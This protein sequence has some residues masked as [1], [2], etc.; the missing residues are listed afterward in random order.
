[1]TEQVK[2]KP[3]ALVQ[4]PFGP[5]L[6]AP[7]E[8][9]DAAHA[10]SGK[11]G[12]VYLKRTPKDFGVVKRF[13]PATETGSFGTIGKWRVSRAFGQL[14]VVIVE[15]GGTWQG[16]TV[17]NATL[18]E[19]APR[20]PRELANVPLYNYYAADF[21]GRRPT[22]LRGQITRILPNRSFEVTYSG[23]SRFTERYVRRGD[24]YVLVGGGDS[25][26]EGC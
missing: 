4:A 24:H 22:N 17:N 6:L 10:S 23:S 25:R 1:M 3:G 21:G 2:F 12:V 15:G 8:V 16:C 13:I 20:G 9:I 7:G 14:P 19:L 26:V 18:L 11:M 5:A